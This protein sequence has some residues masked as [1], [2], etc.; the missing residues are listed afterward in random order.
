MY[1]NITLA[2]LSLAAT[3]AMAV[4]ASGIVIHVGNIIPPGGNTQ[5]ADLVAGTDLS[6]FT[7]GSGFDRL[8]SASDVNSLDDIANSFS[9][10]VVTLAMNTSAGVALIIMSNTAFGISS[11]TASGSTAGYDTGGVNTYGNGSGG[12]IGFGT[13]AS[14]GGFRAVAIVGLL[15]HSTGAINLTQGSA[16][17]V[18]FLAWAG[19]SWAEDTTG[20]FS[21]SGTLNF[22]FE[23]VSNP[24]PAP[25][26]LGCVA[27][28]GAVVVR[29]R[30]MNS[31]PG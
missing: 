3:L 31:K 2:S 5:Q 4:P 29:R 18:K 1:G 21:G 9:G 22:N 11:F 7:T 30:A 17:N 10:S 28:L 26:L 25:L 23:V 13:P 24:V 15:S 20:T 27:L 14:I 12:L 6:L 19:N 16:S 8:M